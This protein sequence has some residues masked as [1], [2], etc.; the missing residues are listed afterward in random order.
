MG[1]HVSIKIVAY[2]VLVAVVVVAVVVVLSSVE[3]QVDEI[4]PYLLRRS[5]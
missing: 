3:V 5:P 2:A 1:H 4:I